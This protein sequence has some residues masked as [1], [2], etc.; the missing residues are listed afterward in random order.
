MIWICRFRKEI[1]GREKSTS[2]TSGIGKLSAHE[3]RDENYETYGLY[4]RNNI[5]EIC[6]AETVGSLRGTS[7]AHIRIG[8]I[9][10]RKESSQS[11]I[12][13]FIPEVAL[14][15]DH[16]VLVEEIPSVY[17]QTSGIAKQNDQDNFSSNMPWMRIVTQFANK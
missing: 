12:S 11:Q 2:E 5:H 7:N 9:R 1:C 3:Y 15:K 17:Y 10:C 6:A 4:L 13:G 8:S 14:V 16:T